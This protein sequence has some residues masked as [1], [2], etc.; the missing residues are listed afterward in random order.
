L[1]DN[2]RRQT[3]AQPIQVVGDNSTRWR[4]L[5]RDGLPAPDSRCGRVSSPSTISAGW[6]ATLLEKSKAGVVEAI[7]RSSPGSTS[8][9]AGSTERTS[10]SISPARKIGEDDQRHRPTSPARRACRPA[11]STAE[12]AYNEAYASVGVKCI[13]APKCPNQ[14]GHSREVM[15]VI[16]EFNRAGRASIFDF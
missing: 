7:A 9:H 13:V 15:H 12:S 8:S 10:R 11:A 6:A 5:Q 14:R 4:D 1:V 16:Y 3:C 2:R